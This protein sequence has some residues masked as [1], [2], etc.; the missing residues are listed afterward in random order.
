MAHNAPS[1]HR[2]AELCI[3]C[4]APVGLTDQFCP[5]CGAARVVQ[6]PACGAFAQ[7]GARRCSDCGGPLPHA[8]SVLGTNASTPTGRR[9]RGLR[10]LMGS[11]VSLLVVFAA[12]AWVYF[13]APER[14]Q[15]QPISQLAVAPPFALAINSGTRPTVLVG[16][17]TRLLES[18]DLGGSW[19]SS[20]IAGAVDAIG[21]GTA[22]ASSIYLAGARLW[23]GGPNGFR[24]VA[25]RLPTAAVQALAVD[26][27]DANR[28]YALIPGSGTY[29]S[30]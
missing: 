26:P 5:S 1:E 27:T 18:D 10:L 4:G 11:T 9:G 25:T 6:C 15:A 20:P 19:T 30:D 13:S 29:R 7:R 2:S 12:V 3:Q 23:Q 17:A 24:P 16:S 22:G 21:V 8:R 14:R 28:L